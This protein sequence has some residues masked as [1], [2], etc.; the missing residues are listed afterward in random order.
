MT[1]IPAPNV[2][3]VGFVRGTRSLCIFTPVGWV[4]VEVGA[5]PYPVCEQLYIIN[6][7]FSFRMTP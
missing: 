6:M 2:G 3:S 7:A 5:W 1:G 4:T